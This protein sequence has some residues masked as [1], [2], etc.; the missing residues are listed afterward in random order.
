M[1]LLR[2]IIS[3]KTRCRCFS[4]AHFGDRK[5]SIQHR[6]RQTAD[7]TFCDI[8]VLYVL[9]HSFLGRVWCLVCLRRKER[10]AIV[11][12]RQ[13]QDLTAVYLGNFQSC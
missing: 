12:Q 3:G 8:A 5:V 11:S 13:L 7:R 1:L 10:R 2:R 6:G 9:M 4:Q